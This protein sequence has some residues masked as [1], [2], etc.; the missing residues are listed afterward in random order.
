MAGRGAPK[1][2]KEIIALEKEV[3]SIR[4]ATPEA[5]SLYS[6]S[7]IMNYFGAG[8]SWISDTL[9]KYDAWE[10]KY[11]FS[12]R[13]KGLERP[14][15]E[16]LKMVKAMDEFVIKERRGHDV[17]SESISKLCDKFVVHRR[18][19]RADKEALI[20]YAKTTSFYD[21]S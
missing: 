13:S 19:H 21:F 9:D 14:G 12:K 10:Q 6:V 1:A 20:S 17:D 8:R 7:N 3:Q 15:Q 4:S 18:N 11:D 16:F 5:L 2:L